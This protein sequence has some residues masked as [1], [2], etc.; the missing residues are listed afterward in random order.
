M[1]LFPWVLTSALCFPCGVPAIWG[2]LIQTLP[3]ATSLQP[4][5]ML[6]SRSAYLAFKKPMI[7]SNPA[8]PTPN[9]SSSTTNLLPCLTEGKH[10]VAYTRN[11]GT[12]LESFPLTFQGIKAYWVCLTSLSFIPSHHAHLHELNSVHHCSH[13]SLH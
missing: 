5:P 7:T 6:S 10:I 13:G 11:Q 8:G 2:D 1:W 4:G 12:I 3:A 9:P